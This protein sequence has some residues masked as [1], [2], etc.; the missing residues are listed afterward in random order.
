MKINRKGLDLEI[1]Q[2]IKAKKKDY[3]FKS[4][5]KTLFKVVEIIL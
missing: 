2:F 5:M 3:G 4:R 1:K